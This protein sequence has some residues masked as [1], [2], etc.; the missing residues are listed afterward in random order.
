MKYHDFRFLPRKPRTNEEVKA[1]RRIE[2]IADAGQVL[3][4]W[5]YCV[6][7]PDVGFLKDLL[8]AMNKQQNYLGFHGEIVEYA[9][10]NIIR[11]LETLN[12]YYADIEQALINN[13]VKQIYEY[14]EYYEAC[15]TPVENDEKD[16][17]VQK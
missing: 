6:G 5:W 9:F 14:P 16:N 3:R 8:T 15:D 4:D 2:D 13:V 11:Q 10:S 1:L 7:K 12:K 17:E